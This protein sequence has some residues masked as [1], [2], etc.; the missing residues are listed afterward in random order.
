MSL[1][2]SSPAGCRLARVVA[3]RVH[4][5][6]ARRHAAWD[7]L[8]SNASD[9]LT[10]LLDARFEA[11]ERAATVVAVRGDVVEVALSLPSVDDAV[12]ATTISRTTD[13]AP[14]LRAAST[15]ERAEWYRQFV[16]SQVLLVAEECFTAGPLLA[17][18]T[19]VAS[20]AAQP[21]VSATLS[22]ETLDHAD[23]G[24]AP[25]DV[26][27]KADPVARYEDTQA[28]MLGKAFSA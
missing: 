13:G 2:A 12:P 25:W 16:A 5:S 22:R 8:I 15:T 1:F 27:T 28:R 21:L 19:V 20:Y 9:V 6:R 10:P 14:A 17:R 23:W 4:R 24:E 7:A 3:G 11:S 18:T 26:L